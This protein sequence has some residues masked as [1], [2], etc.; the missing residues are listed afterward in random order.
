MIK[1]GTEQNG[2]QNKGKKMNNRAK[3]T[4]KTDVRPSIF[5]SRNNASKQLKDRYEHVSVSF[6][7]LHKHG[8]SRDKDGICW[9]LNS[10][11]ADESGEVLRQPLFKR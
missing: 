10:I 8:G 7:E 3:R 1:T 4:F 9:T 2:N 6:D 11:V 5:V